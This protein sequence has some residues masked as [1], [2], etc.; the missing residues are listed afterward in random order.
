VSALVLTLASCGGAGAAGGGGGGG[1]VE[2]QGEQASADEEVAPDERHDPH[3]SD[4][5][6]SVDDWCAAPAGDPCGE[7]R[8]TASCRAD[9][10]CEGVAYRGESLVACALDPRCFASNCPT[11]GCVSRCENIGEAECEAHGYRC[12]WNGALCVRVDACGS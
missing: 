12:S 9:P 2:T 10:R 11:V 7:H 6:M 8:D 3:A 5:G 4:C 1:G